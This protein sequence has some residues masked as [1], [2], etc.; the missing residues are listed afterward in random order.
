[1]AELTISE[2]V[3][4]PTPF[5]FEWTLNASMVRTTI[6][7]KKKCVEMIDVAKPQFGTALRRRS[8][9]RRRCSLR[10]RRV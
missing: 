6:F 2:N 9:G 5:K 10:T 4:E 8:R 3:A 7:E 1:M